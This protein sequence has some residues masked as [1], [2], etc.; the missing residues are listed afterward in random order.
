MWGTIIDF[1]ADVAMWQRVVE[2]IF[3]Q[4]LTLLIV[5]VFLYLSR[6]FWMLLYDKTKRKYKREE[7]RGRVVSKFHL[8][9]GGL[10]LPYFRN[11][12]VWSIGKDEVEPDPFYPESFS[13]GAQVSANYIESDRRRSK[14]ILTE[15]KLAAQCYTEAPGKVFFRFINDRPGDL[16]D[17]PYV[18]IKFGD[19]SPMNL[20]LKIPAGS[21]RDWNLYDEDY[22]L[23]ESALRRH[24]RM[25]VRWHQYE[26][27]QKETVT[28]EFDLEGWNDAFAEIKRRFD[29]HA[30]NGWKDSV[31]VRLTRRFGK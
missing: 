17:N 28:A 11:W 24:P 15:F 31:W 4:V 29:K 13:A 25:S 8:K 2:D 23:I 12:Q 10:K 20:A 9:N 14:G 22:K 5:S 26:N 1:L 18:A 27:G 3:K 21:P 19:E 6:R 16:D 30:S 7:P